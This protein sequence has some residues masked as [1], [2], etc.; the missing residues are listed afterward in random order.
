MQLRRLAMV[1]VAL[2]AL[3][4]AACTPAVPQHQMTTL[5][6]ATQIATAPPS[7]SPTPRTVQET[8]AALRPL[9]VRIE[10]WRCDQTGSLGSG[11][12]LD[13]THVVTVAHNVVG[14]RAGS[15]PGYEDIAVRSIDR[16]V[17]KAKII[18]ID[19]VKDVAL[20]ELKDS[21]LG[22]GG[23][24]MSF[25]TTPAVEG[26]SVIALGYPGARPLSSLQGHVSGLNRTQTVDGKPISGLLQ[27]DAEITQ[28]NSGGPLVSVDG[29]VVGL[30]DAGGIVVIDGEEQARYVPTGQNYA[31]TDVRTPISAWMTTPSAPAAST[32]PLDYALP[33]T[34]KSTH[35]E[36]TGIAAAVSHWLTPNGY[37]TL[38]G[39]ALAQ[40]GSRD[41]FAQAR[42]SE[43]T[44]GVTLLAAVTWKSETTDTAE[45]TYHSTSSTGCQIMHF[46]LTLTTNEGSWTIS[47]VANAD[48]PKPC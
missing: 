2:I 24:G 38:S 16:G 19:T 28:G 27:F 39:N 3:S 18:G 34:V 25:A 26:D 23:T 43:T 22:Q 21:L 32:C 1:I 15:N 9:V 37:G 33:I 5:E 11:Y 6:S 4:S 20:L 36:A 8:I 12:L 30:V 35:P 13:A 17:V 47:D 14:A 40:A 45:V 31:V 7:S 42:A 48:Q 29:Q 41:A 44:S 46:R 10:T